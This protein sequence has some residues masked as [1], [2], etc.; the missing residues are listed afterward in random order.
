M[1]KYIQNISLSRKHNETIITSEMPKGICKYAH[2]LVHMP[3]GSYTMENWSP[4]HELDF[5]K[6]CYKKLGVVFYIRNTGFSITYR[7]CSGDFW[8]KD[9]SASLSND[10]CLF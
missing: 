9:V 3:I 4:K 8:I 1:S 7:Y 5:L 10:N 6:K 2:V